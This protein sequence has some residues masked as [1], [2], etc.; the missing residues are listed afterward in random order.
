M[1]LNKKENVS[2][3]GVNNPDKRINIVKVT[4]TWYNVSVV[5]R[6]KLDDANGVC[7]LKK[8]FALP[9]GL[10]IGWVRVSPTETHGVMEFD[11]VLEGDPPAQ[12]AFL[13]DALGLTL[14]S[15][16]TEYPRNGDFYESY[17]YLAP[18]G[19]KVEA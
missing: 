2:N 12:I 6:C 8:G 16:R 9:D 7:V 15:S 17:T 13:Q 10:T 18:D 4:Q 11:I 14:T 19:G 5:L 3:I 1:L